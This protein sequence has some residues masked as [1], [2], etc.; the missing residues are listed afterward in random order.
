LEFLKSLNPSYAEFNIFNSLPGA[1]TW[2]ELETQGLVGSDVDFLRYS[3][4]SKDNFFNNGHITR[5]EFMEL[6]L[7]MVRKFD[8]HNRSRNGK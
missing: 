1:R 7:F 2:K 5:L 8:A 6:A 4:S 3:Q